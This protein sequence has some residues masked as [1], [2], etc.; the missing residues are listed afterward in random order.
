[1]FLV[2]VATTAA[3]TQQRSS[4]ASIRLTATPARALYDTPVTIRITGLKPAQRVTVRTTTTDERGVTWSSSADFAADQT[5]AVTNG[6][7]SIGGSYTGVNPMGLFE[8]QT[9]PPSGS[10]QQTY[11]ALPDDWRMHVTIQAGAT[12]LASGELSRLYP[13][14]VGVSERQ[15]RPSTAGIYGSVFLPADTASRKPAVVVFGGAEGGVGTIGD[16]GLL[17]AHGYPALAL[18]Y[19]AE[20]GLPTELRRIPLEYF[21]SALRILSQQPGVDPQRMVVWGSSRGSEAAMLAG[22]YYPELVHAVIASVPSASANGGLPDARQPAWTRAGV[23]VAVGS[24]IPVEKI[25]GPVLLVCG[26]RDE[27]WPSCTST[28]GIRD[29]LAAANAALPT[30]LQY[31]VAGH[32]VGNLLPFVPSVVTREATASGAFLDAGG[33]PAADAAGRADG[34]PKLLAF[35]AAVPRS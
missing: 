14:Q 20:P 2:A 17:A 15:Q 35:L 9:P 13:S 27:V 33:S 3:C 22:G 12:T 30:V 1:M 21:A 19:F 5:G 26:G 7:P 18:A 16:A 10:D 28:E 8:T 6:Q 23:A 29:E 34:W 32:L 24:L 4:T 31:P 11:F 25:N